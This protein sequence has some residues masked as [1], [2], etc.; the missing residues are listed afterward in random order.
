MS[1]SLV[2]IELESPTILVERVGR[3]GF[4]SMKD[5]IP[6]STLR[7]AIVTWAVR[8]GM[9]EAGIFARESA[10][11]K[12]LVHPAY[13]HS[14]EDGIT[15][16]PPT[17]YI[18]SCKIKGRLLD[19]LGREGVTRLTGAESVDEMAKPLSDAA[20]KCEIS[21]SIP[22]S[23]KPYNSPVLVGKELKRLPARRMAEILTSVAINKSIKSAERAMLFNYEVIPPGQ[24][25]R[26]LI[27]DMT[28]GDFLSFIRSGGPVFLGRGASR[29]F[30]R[31]RM[32]VLRTW[33]LELLRDTLKKSVENWVVRGQSCS[34]IAVY[35]RSPVTKMM[36][37]GLSSHFPQLNSSWIRVQANVRVAL[38]KDGRPLAIGRRTVFK[39]VSYVTGLPRPSLSCSDRG[40]IFLVESDDDP[41]ILSEAI[42]MG[43]VLG[44]DDLSVLGLNFLE[45]LGW[46][47]D[48]P[49]GR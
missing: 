25:F 26:T 33:E 27:V 6:G 5:W 22:N 20:D 29:G 38:G 45:P 49:L 23:I 36:G 39:S 42:A 18:V 37:W 4:T 9:L 11:P 32:R 17:P 2:E 47:Y 21:R 15:A 13:P 28:G 34:R 16:R 40:S 14:A 8:T 12:L 3:T 31:A 48:D 19:L 43:A 24:R 30:G 41:E 44:W 35:A 1:V 46:W 10:E 7:G